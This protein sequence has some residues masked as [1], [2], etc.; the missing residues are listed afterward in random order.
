MSLSESDIGTAR[1]I[2]EAIAFVD[3]NTQIRALRLNKH[4]DQSFASLKALEYVAKIIADSLSSRDSERRFLVTMRIYH[5]W[6]KGF[7]PTI[8]R[9]ALRS[10]E[11][12]LDYLSLGERRNVKFRPTLELG[13]RLM[14]A[15]AT[16]LHS[17]L[18]CHLPNTL[19]NSVFDGLR[20]E[21]KMVD[22]AIASDVVDVAHREKATWIVLVSDDDDMVPPVFVAESA[23]LPSVDGQVVL[24][25]RRGGGPFLKLEGLSWKI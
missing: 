2:T 9:R 15:S 11:K 19:R 18:N 3:W 7:E 16:R 23:R 17:Y 22:T 14:S 24:A 13:D 5:G 10:A 8:R 1:S 12:D 6:L 25:R 20:E 4:P 21:E